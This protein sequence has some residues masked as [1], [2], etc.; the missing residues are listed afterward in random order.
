MSGWETSARPLA[1]ASENLDG[2]VEN[3]LG[4]VE[5]CTGYIRD[6]SVLSSGKC[7]KILVSQPAC[8]ILQLAMS[9][10]TAVVA[11]E[12]QVHRH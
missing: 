8:N 1:N 6:Y 4:Q 10:V 7:Q 5:F 11:L 3:M 2:R 9:A 12:Y